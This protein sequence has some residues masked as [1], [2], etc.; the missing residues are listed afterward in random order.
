MTG[1]TRHLFD[2]VERS[3]PRVGA[4]RRSGALKWRAEYPRRLLSYLPQRMKVMCAR[5]AGYAAEWDKQQRRRR[6]IVALANTV[7]F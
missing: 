5:F 4:D 3:N 7:H 6:Q 1:R 2:A